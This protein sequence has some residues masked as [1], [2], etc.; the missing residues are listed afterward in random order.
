MGSTVG[1]IMRP[2]SVMMVVLVTGM[3]ASVA[4]AQNTRPPENAESVAAGKAIYE[5]MGEK[6]NS[7]ETDST[8]TNAKKNAICLQCHQADY[9]RKSWRGSIHETQNVACVNCHTIMVKVSDKKQLK[10]K[11]VTKTCAQCH[12]QKRAQMWRSSHMPIREGKVDC[13]DCHNPHGGDGPTLLKLASVNETCYQCHQDKRGPMLWEHAPV[14]ENCAIC[15]EPHGSNHASLLRTKPPYLCQSCHMSALH[16]SEVYDARS[17]AT[18]ARPA[19]RLLGK[20]CLNCHSRIHGS[21][22]PSGGRFQ[23]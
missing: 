15:H 11:T 1:T 14:R 20:A 2:V 18:G 13:S 16:V 6:I 22:H 17:T 3:V 12:A 4:L 8:L 5:G 7:F 9:N 19:G 10:K 23:R 21:N